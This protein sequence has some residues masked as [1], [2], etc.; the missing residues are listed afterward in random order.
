MKRY[1]AIL[2]VGF[3]F[4]GLV[5]MHSC[6]TAETWSPLGLWTINFL[7]PSW[8]HDWTDTVTF[9][10]NDDGGS[11]YGLTCATMCAPQ[12]G[13]W[14]KTGDYSITMTFDFY[15]GSLHEVINLTGTSSEA[16]PN[17][18]TGAGSWTENTGT[19]NMTFSASR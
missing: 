6:K 12:T 1:L 3:L 10:G 16:N 2:L 15:W 13:T 17:A 18:M 5:S 4:L 19:A 7:I 11:V 9:S 14:T 8:S